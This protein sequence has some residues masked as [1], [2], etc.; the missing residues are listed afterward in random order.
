MQKHESKT[1]AVAVFLESLSQLCWVSNRSPGNRDPAN[2]AED[3]GSALTWQN[4]G[5]GRDTLM[6]QQHLF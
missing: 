3:V 4:P 6:A 5:Q 1:Q 2:I